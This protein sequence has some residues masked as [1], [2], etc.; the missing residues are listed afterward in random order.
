M[1]ITYTNTLTAE[2]Y[3][4][5]RTAVGWQP[6]EFGRARTALARSDYLIAAQLEKQ[7]VGMARV[8]H[9]GTVALITDVIVLPEYQGR[10][11]GKTLMEK[12]M[13]YLEALAQGGEIKAHLMSLAGI[14]PF[15]EKFGFFVRPQ[16][17]YGHGM[18]KIIRLGEDE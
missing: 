4:A 13:A 5:L 1:N 6:C 11:I 18:T 8:V 17:R 16:G 15:Y 7:V 12:V 9:D 10:D 14:E 3:N 2:T